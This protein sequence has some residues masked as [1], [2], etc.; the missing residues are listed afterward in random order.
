MAPV[1][2]SPESLLK[3]VLPCA[4]L[5]PA[6]VLAK[7]RAHAMEGEEVP[8]A[9]L[10]RL[11]LPLSIYW[12]MLHDN[13]A[14]AEQ[15]YLLPWLIMA[16]LA[17]YLGTIE[18][19]LKDAP[20]LTPESVSTWYNS[21]LKLLMTGRNFREGHNAFNL[22][23]KILKP[24]GLIDGRKIGL[25]FCEHFVSPELPLKADLVVSLLN[26]ISILCLNGDE[27]WQQ[28]AYG[29][30][31]YAREVRPRLEERLAREQTGYST[32]L[33]PFRLAPE[34]TS[35]P[36]GL[37]LLWYILNILED[38]MLSQLGQTNPGVNYRAPTF[39]A[40]RVVRWFNQLTTYLASENFVRPQLY[41]KPF[42]SL[43]PWYTTPSRHEPETA[44]NT[45][46]A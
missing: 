35:S 23:K 25:R 20:G 15:Q 29:W 13:E 18:V 21:F 46:D 34:V 12:E 22:V 1:L 42:G 5:L 8:L 27:K 45:E 31:D 6:D 26:H 4:D 28:V 2:I 33:N 3:S 36:Q 43:P 32:S 16:T 40:R 7:L 37:H 41:E 19:A 38:Q 39:H 17:D 9:D 24:N 30:N 10:A 11:K 14:D 44:H